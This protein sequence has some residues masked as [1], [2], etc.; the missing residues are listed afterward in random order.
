MLLNIQR[1]SQV[2]EFQVCYATKLRLNLGNC[3]LTDIPTR[4]GTA[5]GEH[6]LRPSLLVSDFPNHRSDYIL[7]D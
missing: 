5:G 7:A 1:T 3:V 4:A 6:C 2:G